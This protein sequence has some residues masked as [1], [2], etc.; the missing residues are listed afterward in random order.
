LAFPQNAKTDVYTQKLPPYLSWSKAR[1]GMIQLTLGIT[2]TTQAGL[3]TILDRLRT[4]SSDEI[5]V[6]ATEP[7]ADAPDVLSVTFEFEP[8][9]DEASSA[10]GAQCRTW[11]HR[12]DSG[13]ESYRMIRDP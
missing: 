11:L 6:T 5:T 10:L 3:N 13:V 4:F 1:Q 7:E 8:A 2:A 12:D 9:S